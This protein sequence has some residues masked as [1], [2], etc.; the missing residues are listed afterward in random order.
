MTPF[1][2]KALIFI[3]SCAL[4]GLASVWLALDSALHAQRL[5]DAVLADGVNPELAAPQQMGVKVMFYSLP[6]VFVA[7]FA[8]PFAL[9]RI[10]Y[11]RKTGPG[12]GHFDVIFSQAWQDTGKVWS[13]KESARQTIKTQQKLDE[14][15]PKVYGKRHNARL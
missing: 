5:L 1:Q 12:Q 2:K 15:T 4:V 14:E 11:G 9:I 10:Y 13:W 6:V 7:G 3:S 8:I